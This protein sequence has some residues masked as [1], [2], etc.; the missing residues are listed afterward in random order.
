MQDMKPLNPFKSIVLLLT[1]VGLNTTQSQAA[2]LPSTPPAVL[3][4][5]D[6]GTPN[7]Q[8]AGTYVLQSS[9]LNYYGNREWVYQNSAGPGSFYWTPDGAGG[10]EN[11]KWAW[12]DGS[13]AGVTGWNTRAQYAVGWGAPAIEIDISTNNWAITWDGGGYGPGFDGIP[14]E[15]EPTPTPE[16]TPEPP[17]DNTGGDVIV[18][19]ASQLNVGLTFENG[20]WIP[21]T[22]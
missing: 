12:W 15:P 3:N 5:G 4:L 7:T 18:E 22:Q 21:V 13:G 20:Q 2:E 11:R 14:L 10:S 1:I 8:M 17:P 6:F 19:Q 16:P 9:Q